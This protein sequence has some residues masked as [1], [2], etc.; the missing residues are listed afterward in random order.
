MNRDVR[1]LVRETMQAVLERDIA[2]YEDL[3]RQDIAAWD[4]LAHVNLVF[5][6]ESELQ[7]QFGADELG[8]LD[9]LS[10]L[11]TAAEAHLSELPIGQNPHA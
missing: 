1:Q 5:A 10:K 3:V 11:V 2:P 7:I 4:S 9:S 8:E 6:I